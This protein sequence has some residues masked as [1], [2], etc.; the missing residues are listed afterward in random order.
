MAT[1]QNI[2]LHYSTNS[3]HITSLRFAA[4]AIDARLTSVGIQSA[5]NFLTE[6]LHRLLPD[7]VR[8]KE[9][10][11]PENMS[12]TRKEFKIK[13]HEKGR[14]LVLEEKITLTPTFKNPSS[15]LLILTFEYHIK[16]DAAVKTPKTKVSKPKAAKPQEVEPVFPKLLP[17]YIR[18]TSATDIRSL[19][20]AKL[21]QFDRIVSMVVNAAKPKDVRE[22]KVLSVQGDGS[23]PCALLKCRGKRLESNWGGSSEN[24]TIDFDIYVAL[25]K[26]GAHPWIA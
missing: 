25:R 24:A 7:I 13:E 20:R 21:P 22:V 6:R 5:K 23:Y 8:V 26:P 2:E 10:H 11:I 15:S 16:E 18:I 12:E 14:S 17:I 1:K 4:A 19:L 9:I 3:R